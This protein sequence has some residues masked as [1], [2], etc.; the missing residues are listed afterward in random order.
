[1]PQKGADLW[2]GRTTTYDIMHWFS[3]VNW[4]LEAVAARDEVK[5]QED[6]SASAD[7]REVLGE[8][9]KKEDAETKCRNKRSTVHLNHDVMLQNQ[10]QQISDPL[11]RRS[12]GKP[13]LGS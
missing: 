4:L 2:H 6:S 9:Q 7:L 3:K 11:K 10:L 8:A 1:M 12:L 13:Q 5:L